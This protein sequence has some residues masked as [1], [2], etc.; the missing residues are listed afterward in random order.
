MTGQTYTNSDSYI[1][2]ASI[3]V[4]FALGIYFVFLL[5]QAISRL[6]HKSSLGR[7]LKLKLLIVGLLVL[8]SNSI[9]EYIS[10]LL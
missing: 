8:F 1:L 9:I 5:A 7:A 2:Y 4:F 6:R 10:D 3:A